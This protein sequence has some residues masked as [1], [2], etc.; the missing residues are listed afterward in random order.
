MRRWNEKQEAPVHHVRRGFLMPRASPMSRKN[1]KKYHF[2]YF[3]LWK[4]LVISIIFITFAMS[5]C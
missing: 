4:Y 1:E 2:N 5:G 3:F